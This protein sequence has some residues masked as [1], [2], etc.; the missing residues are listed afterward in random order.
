MVRAA[1]R[2][3]DDEGRRRAGAA[4]PPAP[5]RP[6]VLVQHGGD[7]GGCGAR[8]LEHERGQ[9]GGSFLQATSWIF[10]RHL[11][12]GDEPGAA[13]R[14]GPAVGGRTTLPQRRLEP[15]AV[16]VGQPA[17]EAQ[18]G[19]GRGLQRL[20]EPQEMAGAL[21]QQ[22]RPSGSPAA[23]AATT[24][25]AMAAKSAARAALSHARIASRARPKVAAA[26]AQSAAGGDRRRSRPDGR[27]TRP[28]GGSRARRR[29]RDR[30]PGSPSRCR[31]AAHRPA[32]AGRR[33][34]RCR[35]RA[36]RPGR[37]RTR[38]GR[39]CSRRSTGAARRSPRTPRRRPGAGRPAD[40]GEPGADHGPRP[41]AR[42]AG[43]PAGRAVPRRRRS[44]RARRPGR[45]RDW[46][47]R[48]GSAPAPRRPGSSARRRS[49]CRRRRR[50]GRTGSGS[51]AN[52]YQKMP[53][54]KTRQDA[55][56]DNPP[57]PWNWA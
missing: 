41:S 50:P 20:G 28:R 55:Y 15:R 4:R 48:P 36:A 7:P 46:P 49:C 30:P 22:R 17:A 51:C 19:R 11:A 26:V 6:R 43:P 24:A 13:D 9:G 31:S 3:G 56:Q 10:R 33:R 21:V 12:G 5:R 23:A 57:I 16:D 2:D 45:G 52:Q 8:L 14:L 35:S 39:R 18:R 27:D 53:L 44:P 29:R 47:A 1:A 38:R 54:G 37:C 42:P 25:G 32:P 40:P 34:P